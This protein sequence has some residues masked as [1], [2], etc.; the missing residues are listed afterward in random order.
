MDS[1][2]LAEDVNCPLPL[3]GVVREPLSGG[4]PGEVIVLMHGFAESGARLYAELERVLP[5]E[6]RIISLNGPYPVPVRKEQ[7][8]GYAWYFYY[9]KEYIIAPQAAATFVADGLGGL[10]PEGIPV[11]IIGFS[12][13]GYLAP[14]AASR[15]KNL[16]RMI[17]I[18]GEYLVDEWESPPLCPVA[19][20]HGTEDRVVPIGDGES[21]FSR[22]LARGGEGEFHPVQGA[23]HFI[24]DRLLGKLKEVM[25]G[26]E[27]AH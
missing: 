26:Q 22:M 14:F 10:L 25:D 16:R 8:V 15:V 6:A 4:E 23:G 27:K 5:E 7:R 21:T 2:T 20:I 17:I 13:G 3:T 1:K 18:N 24:D 12:Q 9:K 19:A 11:T